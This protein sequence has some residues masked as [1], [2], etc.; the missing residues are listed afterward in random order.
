[1]IWNE[2]SPA[3]QQHYPPRDIFEAGL[4]HHHIANTAYPINHNWSVLH[5]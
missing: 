3:D 2:P 5:K 4:R 1:M